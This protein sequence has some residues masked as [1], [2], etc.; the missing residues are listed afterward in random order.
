MRR[1]ASVLAATL[2]TVLATAGCQG[3]SAAPK[4]RDHAYW[5]D[6][7][8]TSLN[9]PAEDVRFDGVQSFLIDADTSVDYLVMLRCAS[10]GASGQDGDQLDLFSGAA[11]YDHPDLL[12][13][14]VHVW[15]HR[16]LA[17]DVAQDCAEVFVRSADAGR[18][19]VWAAS[20]N[21]GAKGGPLQVRR[22][23]TWAVSTTCPSASAVRSSGG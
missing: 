2:I 4:Q 5:T 22:D 20:W 13:V 23:A 18:P 1:P 10:P 11:G 7:G 3:F 19:A 17:L 15:D 6:A 14:I 16:R 21:P 12:G 8:R 9:C